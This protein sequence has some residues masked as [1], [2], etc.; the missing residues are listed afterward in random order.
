[1]K[2]I[3]SY[4]ASLVGVIAAYVAAVAAVMILLTP[5]F[6]RIFLILIFSVVFITVMS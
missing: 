4:V 3:L 6:T 1:M 2:I 5:G